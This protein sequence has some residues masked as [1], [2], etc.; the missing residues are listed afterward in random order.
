VGDLIVSL[1][2]AVVSTITEWRTSFNLVTIAKNQKYENGWLLKVKIYIWFYG[3]N[4]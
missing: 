4:S 1:L 3:D 2:N